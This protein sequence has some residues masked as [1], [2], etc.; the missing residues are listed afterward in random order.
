LV[1][2]QSFCGL[3]EIGHEDGF[4]G[5]IHRLQYPSASK[6]SQVISSV[7]QLFVVGIVT[8]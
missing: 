4:V 1:S 6:S 7:I 8:A 5:D 2:L 3:Q